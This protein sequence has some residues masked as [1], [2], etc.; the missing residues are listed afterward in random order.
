MV[1]RRAQGVETEIRAAAAEAVDS[2]GRRG[3]RVVLEG[4]GS[5]YETSESFA[6]K[7]GIA[8]RQ[9]VTKTR[10]LLRAAPSLVWEGSSRKTAEALLRL[11]EEAGGRGRIDEIGPRRESEAAADAGEPMSPPQTGEAAG[12][13]TETSRSC[14]KCGFPARD[15]ERYCPFCLSPYEKSPVEQ[16]RAGRVQAASG[17][18]EDRSPSSARAAIPPKRLLMYLGIVLIALVLQIFLTR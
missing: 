10:H 8:I 17:A 7:F 15:G 16:R 2:P 9:P 5:D 14:P 3:F 6:I 4:I 12:G 11:I 1:D 13:E 18:G